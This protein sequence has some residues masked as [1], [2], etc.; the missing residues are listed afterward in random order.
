VLWIFSIVEN[1]KNTQ[2]I[3]APNVILE[4]CESD[5]LPAWILHILMSSVQHNVTVVFKPDERFQNLS[6]HQ[7]KE[8]PWESL[9]PRKFPAIIATNLKTHMDIK[10]DAVS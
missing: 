8:D 6:L 10:R 9:Q 4:S 5:L 3:T 1:G 2:S 7:G